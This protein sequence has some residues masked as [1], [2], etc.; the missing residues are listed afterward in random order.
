MSF[1]TFLINV[2]DFTVSQNLQICNEILVFYMQYKNW[3][4]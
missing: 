4:I 1:K 3:K 2:P